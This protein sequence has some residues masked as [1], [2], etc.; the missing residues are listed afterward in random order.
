MSCKPILRLKLENTVREDLF[1]LCWYVGLESINYNNPSAGR[2]M[3]VGTV[4]K[5]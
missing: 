1:S 4:I 5:Y 3:S 2:I